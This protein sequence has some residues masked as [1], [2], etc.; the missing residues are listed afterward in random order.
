MI[1]GM[2]VVCSTCVGMAL[3]KRTCV[4]VRYVLPHGCGGAA[5]GAQTPRDCDVCS[6]RVGV[7][8]GIALPNVFAPQV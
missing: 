7:V 3:D 2:H 5:R 4:R 1:A 8:H 6:T